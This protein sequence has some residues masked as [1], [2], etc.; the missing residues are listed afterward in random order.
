[1]ATKPLPTARDLGALPGVG[2]S[3]G[4]ARLD[5]SGLTRGMA[6]AD[7]ARARGNASIAAGEQAQAQALV[8][9]G[10]GVAGLGAGV[11]DYADTMGRWEYAR[12]NTD[13]LTHKIELDQRYDED[14]DYTTRVQRYEKD[15]EKLK[16]EAAGKISHPVYRERFDLDKTP[17]VARAL[18]TAQDKARKQEGDANVT[19]MLSQGDKFIE[20]ATATDNEATRREVIDSHN[21]LVDAQVERGFLTR[22]QGLSIKKDWARRYAAQSL[23]VLPAEQRLALLRPH[24]DPSAG[25]VERII[26]AESGNDP[27]A[28][29]PKSSARGLGQFIESTWLDLIR[30]ERPALAGRSDKELLELRNDPRLS[31]D[32]VAAHARDNAQGLAAQGIEASA[33]NVYLAHFLGLK[34]AIRVLQA[35]PDKPVAELLDRAA[36]RANPGVLGGKTAGSVAAWA[37]QRMGGELRTGQLADVIPPGERMRLFREASAEVF[38]RQTNAAAQRSEQIERSIIDAGAGAGELPPRELIETDP[39]LTEPQRNTLLRQHASVAGDLV[40]WQNFL[41]RFKDPD[42]GPFNP[43]DAEQR[44]HADRTFRSLGGGLDSLQ[45]VVDRTGILPSSAA[46]AL[47]ADMISTNPDRV[48]SAL[49]TTSNLINRNPNIFVAVPG[50]AEFENNAV[51]FNHYVDTLGMTAAEAANRVIRDQS[52]EYQASVKARLKSEDIDARIKKELSLGDLQGAFDQV[53]WIP[54]TDPSVGFDPRQRQEM[55]S[56]FAEVVK[57]RYLETGDMALAKKQAADQ[58]KKTWGVSRVNGSQVVMQYPPERAPAYAGIENASEAIARQAVD[59]VKADSGTD[60]DRATIRLAPIPGATA[61][62]YKSGQPVPYMLMW[63][64]RQGVV[65][66]LNPGRAF[67]ADPASM[68]TVQGEGR[69]TQFEAARQRFDMGRP[70]LETSITGAP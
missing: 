19:Y 38:R 41:T 48:A 17:D 64:D 25:V 47:R 54:F 18:A 45:A 50:K 66:M 24:A 42:S 60:I 43:F 23:S 34:G 28:A 6:R 16:S 46:S 37:A 4:V 22:V 5:S 2:G 12:A 32:M 63:A 35:D 55:F 15:I 56:Q 61:A 39:V 53:P 49:T 29:N 20:Q 65:H 21:E 40:G 57:D 27:T 8:D 69:R 9:L 67:V 68:R 70:T 59:A 36:I 51:A 1:M 13:F 44:K 31:R 11:A 7:A 62:A 33:G 26:G 3:R 52:P 14:Q 58:V 10:K 30:R